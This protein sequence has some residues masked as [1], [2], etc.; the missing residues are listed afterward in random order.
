MRHN[1]CPSI[2]EH[3]LVSFWQLRLILPSAWF[4][5]ARPSYLGLDIPQNQVSEFLFVPI[6][7]LADVLE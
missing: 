7:R 4:S 5:D 3:S 6:V 1:P 2:I